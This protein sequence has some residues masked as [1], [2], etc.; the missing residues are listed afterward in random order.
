MRSLLPQTRLALF[1]VVCSRARLQALL[2][3]L[4]SASCTPTEVPK[5]DF[6][7]IHQEALAAVREM[8]EVAEWAPRYTSKSGVEIATH[9]SPSSEVHMLR[10]TVLVPLPVERVHAH[11]KAREAAVRLICAWYDA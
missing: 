3:C 10:S 7:L 4:K 6:A 8:L 11:Y 5:P 1:S 2:P 9:A